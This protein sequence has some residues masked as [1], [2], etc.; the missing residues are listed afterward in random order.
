MADRL[1][2]LAIYVQRRFRSD[3]AFD[4]ASSLS[5]TSLLSLVPLLAIALAVLAAFPV[6]DS[7][8]DSLQATIFRYVVPEVGEQV[9]YYVSEFVKNAGKLTAAGVVGL[10]V[11]A[12][13][14]LVAIESSFNQIFRATTPRSPLSRVLVYWTALTLGPLLLAASFSL[15]AWLE[16]A[17]GWVTPAG[18]W[19]LLVR[20]LTGVAP[21]LLLMAAFCLLYRLVPNRRVRLADAAT[22]GICAGLAFAGL[23]WGFGLYVA[24]ARAYQSIYGAVA[25][26][27]IFLFWMYLSWMVVLFGAE[28]TAA[29]PEWRRRRESLGGPLS[30]RR[31]LGLALAVIAVLRD[32]QRR[33]GQGC[34]Q[35]DLPERIGEAA[36]DLLLVIEPLCRDRFVLETADG[37]LVMGRDPSVATLQDLVRALGLGL[38]AGAAEDGPPLSLVAD[39][40]DVAARAE[41]RAFDVPLSAVLDGSVELPLSSQDGGRGQKVVSAP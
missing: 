25:T 11:S 24:N 41:A 33:S 27:P 12:I 23:R 10:A 16:A 29:L 7:A 35:D 9:Q 32:D 37:R 30:A 2:A 39:R 40:L 17:S 19:Q 26:V 14:V 8:R 21:A 3:G 15:W 28:L 36:A 34:R 1:A 13:L 18:P 6:F 4:M 20:L 5:Y 22:G 38:A 31:L